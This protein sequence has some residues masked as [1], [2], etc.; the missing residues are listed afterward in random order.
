MVVVVVMMVVQSCGAS[1]WG[2]L[3]ECDG[4]APWAVFISHLVTPASSPVLLAIVL[5]LTASSH[6]HDAADHQRPRL[7]LHGTQVWGLEQPS[8][9]R[10]Q[11]F[12]L[13]LYCYIHFS[14]INDNVSCKGKVLYTCYGV[15]F[16]KLLTRLRSGSWLACINRL[17][18]IT[19]PIDY[20]SFFI[21][22]SRRASKD[23]VKLHT[24]SLVCVWLNVD[25][26]ISSLW[27]LVSIVT[28]TIIYLVFN[29][30]SNRQPTSLV[31]LP[32]V[33][34]NHP[35]WKCMLSVYNQLS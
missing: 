16:M 26:T 9:Q 34:R 13:S 23:T 6:T 21:L 25:K 14:T 5:Q 10:N 32:L 35:R 30:Q 31:S 22:L 29:V 20:F 3:V 12:S 28:I 2:R 15:T 4:C 17:Q 24:V 11:H 1:G 33:L 19:C 18:D 8:Y 7:S 27:R